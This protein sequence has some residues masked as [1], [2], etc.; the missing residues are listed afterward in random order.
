M[1]Q[2][3]QQEALIGASWSLLEGEQIVTG[4]AG[5][6]DA[7]TQEPLLSEHQIQVGSITKTLIATGILRLVT[8]EQITLETSVETL[9]TNIEPQTLNP[10]P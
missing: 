8:T 2:K 6:K 5:F 4:T 1:A 7:R 9:L 3:L 10:K